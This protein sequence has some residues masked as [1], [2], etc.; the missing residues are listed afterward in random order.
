MSSLISVS[1][2]IKTFPGLVLAAGV[3]CLWL[4]V[5][6][7]HAMTGILGGALIVASILL[8]IYV[9][10]EELKLRKDYITYH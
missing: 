3:F 5:T 4:G 8:F 7:S 9:Y 1:I 10:E 2:W 6:Y